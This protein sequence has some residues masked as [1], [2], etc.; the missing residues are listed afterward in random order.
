MLALVSDHADRELGGCVTFLQ[1][2]GCDVIVAEGTEATLRE[3]NHAAPDLVLMR[4]PASAP[5]SLELCRQLRSGAQ[6]RHTAVIVLTDNDDAYVR[7]RI[8][9]A[10]ATM[11]VRTPVAYPALLVRVRRLLAAKRRAQ[12]HQ[13]PSSRSLET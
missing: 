12:E 6:T 5:E 11:I 9:G 1:E 4:A 10:G 3:A 2:S 7:D 8:I 13:R